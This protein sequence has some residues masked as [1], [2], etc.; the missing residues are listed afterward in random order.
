[1][2]GNHTYFVASAES[3]AGILVHNDSTTQPATEPSANPQPVTGQQT[4]DAGTL[5]WTLKAQGD[6]NPGVSFNATFTPKEA[7]GPHENITFIQVVLQN[8]ENG[9][10]VFPDQEDTNVTD[11]Q[12]F[13]ASP[14]NYFVD[15]NK[16]Q[17]A[18]YYGAK[19]DA[20]GGLI[21]DPGFGNPGGGPRGTPA[22][23]SDNPQGGGEQ[24]KQFE[25]FA[26]NID[27]KTI[28]GGVKWGCTVI[29]GSGGAIMGAD[30]K[31]HELPP[32]PPKFLLNAEFAPKPSQAWLDAV[33][34]W[35]EWAKHQNGATTFP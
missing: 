1:V 13:L 32:V 18:P 34:R 27:S 21:V 5:E 3:T 15:H 28:Y 22:R 10:Q 33:D 29:A 4:T 16:G 31:I 7:N 12:A 35:N 11:W 9:V 30:G 6:N 14:G 19:K 25:T 8:T 17:Q 26:V 23:E 2:E 20:R 24:V